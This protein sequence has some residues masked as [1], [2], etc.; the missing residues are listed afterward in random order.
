VKL[1]PYQEEMLS[2]VRVAYTGGARPVNAV[3]PPPP[4]TP[5]PPIEYRVV[6]LAHRDAHEWAALGYGVT[7]HAAV[8]AIEQCTAAWAL[9]RAEL[10]LASDTHRETYTAAFYEAADPARDA[11]AV[12]R[13]SPILRRAVLSISHEEVADALGSGIAMAAPRLRMALG[14]P[15]LISEVVGAIRERGTVGAAAEVVGC[16]VARLHEL[17]RGYPELRRAMDEALRGG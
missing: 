14:D 6:A 10:H 16:T 12:V 13:D 15:R 3:R 17:A 1:R 9:A 8:T 2:A 11:L 5:H 7:D 4:A